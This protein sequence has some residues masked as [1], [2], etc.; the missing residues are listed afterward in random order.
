MASILLISDDSRYRED[1]R[2]ALRRAGFEIILVRE[3]LIAGIRALNWYRP[4]VII[5]DIKSNKLVGTKI[6]SILRHRH[7]KIPLLLISQE[8]QFS[9]PLRR[10]ATAAM[11]KSASIEAVAA[12][13][14]KLIGPSA[15]SKQEAHEI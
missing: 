6:L 12:M 7:G 5:C 2:S 8:G 3:D 15:P 14:F 4:K 10:M 9:D 13:A 1:C 11:L